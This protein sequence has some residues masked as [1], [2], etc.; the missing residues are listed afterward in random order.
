MSTRREAMKVLAAGVGGAA[1]GV[2]AAKSALPPEQSVDRAWRFLTP[3]EAEAVVAIAE[4]I[5]PADRSP[6]K[7][8]RVLSISLTNNSQGSTAAI[9]QRIVTAFVAVQASCQDKHGKRFENLSW[10]SQ[11]ELLKAMEAGTLPAEFWEPVSAREF[12]RLV[13]EHSMQGF[14]GSPRHGGNRDYVSYRMMGLEY[15]YVIGQ[16]R[17][18]E[19]PE[20][21]TS[22]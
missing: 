19:A 8:T 3:N 9:R 4:Q 1:M 10:D 5:I 7:R 14:Y 12:F 20:D 13:R 22:G 18:G 2:G 15:P 6:A 17:Y 11:T 21:H 16:N